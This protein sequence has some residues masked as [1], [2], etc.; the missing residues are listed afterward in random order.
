MTRAYLRP[1]RA[2]SGK[3]VADGGAILLLIV[4]AAFLFRGHL[5]GSVVFVGNHDRLTYFLPVR[6]AE[7][8]AKAAF[9]AAS[10]WNED[11]FMGF[12]SA[13]LPGAT[14]AISP[15]QLVAEFSSRGRFLYWAGV[16]VAC[17]AALTAV[18][19][20]AC[21]RKL[22]RGV[23]PAFAGAIVY[24]CCTQST[25]RLVQ[26][27]G[28]AMLLAALPAGSWLIFLAK[29]DNA[30]RHLLGLAV[31]AGVALSV[32]VGPLTIY[33]LAFWGGLALLQAVLT[34][35]ST[36]LAVYSAAVVAGLLICLPH[37]WGVAEELKTFVR[38]S[39]TGK[40]FDAVYAFFN[41]RP[42][43]IFRWFDD[44]FFGR[45][46]AEAA[47][48]GININLSEGLQ[49][50]SSTYATLL[51]IAILFTY[52]QRRFGLFR[53]GFSLPAFMGLVLLAV[54]AGVLTKTGAHLLYL[55]FLKAPLLHSRIVILGA[56]AMS[57]LVALGLES[58]DDLTKG[59]F[60]HLAGKLATF[61]LAL[62]LA[63]A[64]ERLV[65]PAAAALAKRTGDFSMPLNHESLAKIVLCTVVFLALFGL[66]GAFARAPRA[67]WFL[68]SALCCLI[69]VQSLREADFRMNGPQTR[70]FPR[71]FE[72]DNLLNVSAD[73]LCP[74]TGR[75]L[76]SLDRRLE[77]SLYRT[78]FISDPDQFNGFPAPHLA[79]FWG[80]R[81]VEGYL[82]GVPERLAALEW[83]QN[84]RGFRTIAFNS[85]EQLPWKMLGVLNV[86]YAA[87]VNTALYFN[88]P[89]PNANGGAPSE[90]DL[91]V[92]RNPEPV[93]PRVFFTSHTV[94]VPP[95]RLD[96]DH[97]SRLPAEPE[98]ES[99]VEGVAS[100]ADWST[101]GAIDS[102]FRGDRIYLRVDASPRTRFLVIN[103]LYHPRWFAYAEGRELKVYPVNTVMRGIEIPAGATRVSLEF[104]PFSQFSGWWLFPFAGLGFLALTSARLLKARP[105]ASDF[106]R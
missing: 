59:A 63:L 53:S 43:E 35:R 32:A 87:I 2:F 75:E 45:Y 41:V 12:D 13:D 52:R 8:D 100:P 6:L 26:S 69:V 70:S 84:V 65:P 23:I 30:V 68:F 40:T 1:S 51:V 61:G 104:R 57:F 31:L 34:R 86:K 97:P 92:I 89:P 101:E 98:K 55:I 62:V 72:R 64:I 81:T 22:S 90:I 10:A 60:S 28:A 73:Q 91:H 4:A 18:S 20:Y 96:R 74:P 5:T 58:L 66:I 11:S 95:F 15:M 3:W 46:P 93:T 36:A 24:L 103:E 76:A 77:T 16:A 54:M 56:L 44:G 38:D 102:E 47:A 50:Y 105:H 29:P 7:L 42:H 25:M 27:D 99:F 79:V 94:P 49:L 33:I 71:P 85:P 39:G 19:A 88:L 78:V 9:G 21:L 14:T 80:I 48:L 37:I 82:S 17:L 67:L 106:G 83:P